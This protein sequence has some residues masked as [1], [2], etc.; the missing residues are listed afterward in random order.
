MPLE[1]IPNRNPNVK[2]EWT[3]RQILP[4]GWDL[5]ITHLMSDFDEVAE[6]RLGLIESSTG[7]KTIRANG[8]KQPEGRRTSGAR[9]LFLGVYLTAYCPAY[10]LRSLGL[11]LQ[12]LFDVQVGF[13]VQHL[14]GENRPAPEC[15]YPMTRFMSRLQRNGGVLYRR[16]SGMDSEKI[17]S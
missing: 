2:G 16:G 9:F 4:R 13:A 10:R 8:L 15:D 7:T 3:V 11:I 6:I 12:R 14:T 5:L 17:A 1:K